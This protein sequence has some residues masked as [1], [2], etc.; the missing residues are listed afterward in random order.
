MDGIKIDMPALIEVKDFEKRLRDEL[1]KAAVR[2][3]NAWQDNLASGEG[4]TSHGGPYINTG[5][6]V[7]SIDIEPPSGDTVEIFS[8]AIQVLTAEVGQAP[9]TMPSF[10]AISDW[11]HEKLQIRRDDPGHYPIVQKIRQN[12]FDKGLKGF[13]PMEAAIGTV[14]ADLEKRIAEALPDL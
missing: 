8:D 4:V 7:A 6:A 12:I 1:Y 13:A 10:T 5:E 9:G 14:S 2:M 11:V 3:Q